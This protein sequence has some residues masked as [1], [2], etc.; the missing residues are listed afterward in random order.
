[1]RRN[2]P[3]LEWPA[4]VLLSFS[5]LVFK[6][7]YMFTGLFALKEFYCEVFVSF[8]LDLLNLLDIY[9]HVFNQD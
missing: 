5:F 6:I 1:M 3:R 4:C 2:L 7:Y 8:Y 9:T